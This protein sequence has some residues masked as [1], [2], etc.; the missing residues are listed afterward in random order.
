MN[1]ARACAVVMMAAL[2]LGCGET[3][4]PTSPTSGNVFLPV[5]SGTWVGALSLGTVNSGECVG[6]DLRNRVGAFPVY[7]QGGT[8]TL[9]QV[10]GTDL[11]ATVRSATTGDSCTYSGTMG[12]NAFALTSNQCDVKDIVVQCVDGRSRVMEL[13]SSTINAV[14]RGETATGTVSTRYNI[15]DPKKEAG[16]SGITIEYT[17]NAAR[18]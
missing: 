18:P 7:N 17:F 9:A 10:S 1:R 8:V 13:V 4:A 11:T 3:P 2:T 5:L 12:V 6:D 16:I 14:P 15:Y